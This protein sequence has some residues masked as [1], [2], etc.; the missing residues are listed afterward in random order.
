[1]QNLHGITAEDIAKLIK[2][3]LTTVKSIRNK[4]S[5]VIE[6]RVRFTEEKIIKLKVVALINH[7]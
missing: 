7:R 1:M 2:A 6:Q 5:S 3:G 4:S